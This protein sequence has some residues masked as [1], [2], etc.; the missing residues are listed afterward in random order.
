MSSVPPV[1]WQPQSASTKIADNPAD[2]R[3]LARQD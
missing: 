3:R 2:A 1:V